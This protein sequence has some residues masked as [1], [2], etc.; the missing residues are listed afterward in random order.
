AKSRLFDMLAPHA[1]AVI[2]CDD[3]DSRKVA[4]A[5]HATGARVTRIA[6]SREADI[7]WR[8]GALMTAQ[9]AFADLANAPALRGA[10]NGQNAAAAA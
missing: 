5:V 2:G 4:D 8:D 7:F 10:H 1:T 9:T 3:D 6:A